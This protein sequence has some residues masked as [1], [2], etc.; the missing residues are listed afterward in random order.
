MRLFPWSWRRMV[1]WDRVAETSGK[2][3]E[4]GKLSKKR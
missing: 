4:V 2:K 1:A 3:R